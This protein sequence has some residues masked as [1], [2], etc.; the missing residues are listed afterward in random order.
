MESTRAILNTLSRWYYGTTKPFP[1]L[2]HYDSLT[3]ADMFLAPEAFKST[4]FA[5]E[6]EIMTQKALADKSHKCSVFLG[7]AHGVL[8]L[9][10]SD[11][12]ELLEEHRDDLDSKE[13]V[14][15]FRHHFPRAVMAH[16]TGNWWRFLRSQITNPVNDLT[17]RSQ[18]IF[19][20]ARE[21]AKALEK[22]SASEFDLKK[23]AN[24]FTLEVVLRGFLGAEKTSTEIR[25]KLT[26]LISSG[27]DEVVKFNNIAWLTVEEFIPSLFR[28]KLKSDL[29]LKQ[30]EGIIQAILDAN[31]ATVWGD[32]A[33]WVT[34][35]IKSAEEAQQINPK[36]DPKDVVNDIA[37]LLTAG[38]ETTAKHF[39]FTFL[40]V[41]QNKE[42]L[43]KITDEVSSLG[44]PDSWDAATFSHTPYLDA[45]ILESLRLH[46]PLPYRKVK[47][48][49][50]FQTKDGLQFNAGDHI[51]INIAATQRLE[52]EYKDPERFLPERFLDKSLALLI[53]QSSP[54]KYSLQPFGIGPRSC[55]GARLA[56]L[57]VKA[58][59]ACFVFT[60]NLNIKNPWNSKDVETT[61]SA[62]PINVEPIQI[63]LRS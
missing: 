62:R 35:R 57:E 13:S 7:G 21:Y 49:K 19:Q 60:F 55:P 17:T 5:E 51:F 30:A 59:L 22:T 1:S 61:F 40:E 52:S 8:I 29:L 18:K 26:E 9:D 34:R 53:S 31:Q 42:V 39:A 41:V 38:S 11:L 28:A 43:Q 2:P 46:P 25:E 44:N 48:S 12:K 27:V 56:T 58:A 36:F 14:T 47:V 45:V 50:P 6:I 24:S 3:I 63:S 54:M 10:P 16:P 23:M 33:N 32:E 37:F 15:I 4:K 20:I